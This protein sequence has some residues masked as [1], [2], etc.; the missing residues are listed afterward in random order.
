ML[1]NLVGI[2]QKQQELKR[3]D[4]LNVLITIL[5]RSSETQLT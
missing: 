2:Y 5:E 4:R 1:R 3:I